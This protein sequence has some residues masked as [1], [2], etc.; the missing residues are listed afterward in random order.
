MLAGTLWPVHH[1]AYVA[2]QAGA[3]DHPA[4][5]AVLERARVLRLGDFSD[6]ERERADELAAHDPRI[7]R[8]LDSSDHGFTQTMAAG[9][10]LVD[11]WRDADAY[12][13]AVLDA[14][15]DAARFGVW[16]PLPAALLRD[17]APGYCDDQ[18]RARAPGDWFATAL[19]YARTTVHGAASPLVPVAGRE[20]GVITGYR[21]ADYLLQRAAQER[22]E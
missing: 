13:A 3:E 8:A 22:V 20:M 9:P 7:R 21:P 6:A 5:R 17:A 19:A 4:A 14:A 2:N 15:L 11:R 1:A 10:Q 12:G 18:A 16:G